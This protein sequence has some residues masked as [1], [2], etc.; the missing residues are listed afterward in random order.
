MVLSGVRSVAC[1]RAI[2]R[3]II[4]ESRGQCNEAQERCSIQ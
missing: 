3:A 2:G 4:S 1:K